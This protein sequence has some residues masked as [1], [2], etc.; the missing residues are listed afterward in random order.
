MR[1]LTPQE[2]LLAAIR[3]VEKNQRLPGGPPLEGGRP[4]KESELLMLRQMARMAL[5]AVQ[6]ARLAEVQA[7]QVKLRA[8]KLEAEIQVRLELLIEEMGI[9]TEESEE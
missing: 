6:S 1:I 7:N 9:E 4:G 2:A 5:D 3:A 8:M